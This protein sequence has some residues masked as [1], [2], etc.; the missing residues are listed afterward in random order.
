M[1]TKAIRPRDLR[2]GLFRTPGRIRPRAS[3]SLREAFRRRTAIAG[4]H[5]CGLAGR[6]SMPGLTPIRTSGRG[7][8]RGSGQENISGPVDR[9]MRRTIIRHVRL[10]RGRLREAFRRWSRMR[11]RGSCITRAGRS[12][13]TGAPTRG[14]YR[15]PARSWLIAVSLTSPREAWPGAEKK[16]RGAPTGARISQEMRHEFR[17]R[18]L[19]GAPRPRAS[20]RGKRKRGPPRGQHQEYGR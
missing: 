7:R 3:A 6:S 4:G 5:Y 8:P 9:R 17:R 12:G 19:L 13:G 2:P 14:H 15:P 20:S 1:Q 10:G 18:A 16:P 11:S